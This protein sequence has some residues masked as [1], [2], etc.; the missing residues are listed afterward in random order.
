MQGKHLNLCII[1]LTANLKLICFII[2]IFS[3]GINS[4]PFRCYVFKNSYHVIFIHTKFYQLVPPGNFL[5]WPLLFYFLFW[6]QI[7]WCLVVT[8]WWCWDLIWDSHMQGCSL[9]PLSH[10][11]NPLFFCCSKY[12]MPSFI[13]LNFTGNRSFKHC[14]FNLIILIT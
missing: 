6:G 13:I 11:S 14:L 3:Q 1:S 7:W 8:P 4:F 12:P 2:L 10:L 5:L 9:P